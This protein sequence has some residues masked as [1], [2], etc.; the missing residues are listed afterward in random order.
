MTNNNQL[1][2]P[3]L[4]AG[5][6]KFRGKLKILIS[7]EFRCS[8]WIQIFPAA[9]IST[10]ETESFVALEFLLRL[11]TLLRFVGKFL[12]RVVSFS[13]PNADCPPVVRAFREKLKLQLERLKFKPV[14]C[15]N[16]RK[17]R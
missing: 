10:S 17:R 5:K 6:R 11:V 16:V 8:D 9:K 2:N 14:Q 4:A 15:A 1:E 12:F 3:R 13:T 7:G